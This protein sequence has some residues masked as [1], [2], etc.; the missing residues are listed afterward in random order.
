MSPLNVLPHL[1][2]EDPSV[3]GIENSRFTLPIHMTMEERKPH[4]ILDRPHE[5]DISEFRYC[6]DKEEPQHSFIEMTLQK[7][8]DTVTLRFWQPSNLKIEPGFPRPTRGMVFYDRS[9][10]GLEGINVEVADFEASWGSI[11]FCARD[12]ERCLR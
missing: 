11:T 6:V 4:P 7:N 5:Y 8:T 3:A 1:F 12:V 2:A 9:S 10:D